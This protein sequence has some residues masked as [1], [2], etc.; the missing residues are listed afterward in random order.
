MKYLGREPEFS[1]DTV[2]GWTDLARNYNWYNHFKNTDD[3]KQ[4][5]NEF[6]KANKIKINIS[7]HNTNTFGWVARM[8]PRGAKLDE[9]TLTKFKDYLSTLKKPSKN[10]VV[11]EKKEET[12]QR[13]VNRLD[14]WLPDFE[15]AIDNF[16]GPFSAYNYLTSNNVPQMYAKMIQEHYEPLYNEIKSAYNK[17]DD[18]LVEAYKVHRRTELKALMLFVKGIVDDCDKFLSN[19]KKERKPRKKRE[20]SV[21]S[22]LK[23]FKY[24]QNDT[25]LKLT[26]EDPAKI[27]GSTSIYVLNT[28]Y[29]TLT[30]FHAKN[31][32]TLSINR[33]AIANYD[34]KTS[35]TKRAGRALNKVID[36]INN[37]TKKS[38]IKVIDTI[39]TDDAKFTDRLNDSCIILKVDK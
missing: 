27:I 9:S 32:E 13:Q 29:K 19:V 3:A 38:R 17:E 11:I 37:G 20:K 1:S 21:D 7:N 2:L 23:H 22:L 28:K 14:Q 30:V 26:S 25:A 36:A 4:Y 39:K 6:C 35:R 18:Q 12:P 33:T 5:L 24:Q 31:G 15:E 34:E 16:K 8:I 10:E